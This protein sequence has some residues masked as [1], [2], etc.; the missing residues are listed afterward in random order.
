MQR[1][2]LK[3][4]MPWETPSILKLKK[5]HF[6]KNSN[7]HWPM[8]LMENLF[9][10]ILNSIWMGVLRMKENQLFKRFSQIKKKI[11]KK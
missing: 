8:G 1:R 7:N 2:K 9:M 3:D 10:Q 4:M 6:K 11:Q 5:Y